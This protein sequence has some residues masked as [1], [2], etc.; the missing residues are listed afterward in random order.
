MQKEQRERK[1]NP[2]TQN[3]PPFASETELVLD[4]LQALSAKTQN[5]AGDERGLAINWSRIYM[6]IINAVAVL[7]KLLKK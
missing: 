7:P 4:S 2:L 3:L 5:R 1:E 6:R